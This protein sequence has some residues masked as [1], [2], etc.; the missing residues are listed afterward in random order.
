VTPEDQPA[1]GFAARMAFALEKDPNEGARRT[2]LHLRI[3]AI[4]LTWLVTVPILLLF[5]L[6][7]GRRGDAIF[8]WAAFCTIL[9]PF[10]AAV[11][12]TKNRRPGLGGIFVVLTLLMVLPAVAIV[13]F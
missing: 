9:G 8:D 1:D 3:I 13:R 4:M 5:G 12:A 10:L 2:Q 6:T 7:G 11:V